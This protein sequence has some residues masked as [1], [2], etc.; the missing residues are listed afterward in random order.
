LRNIA[1]GRVFG[2]GALDDRLEVLVE[3]VLNI[4]VD[5]R[6]HLVWRDLRVLGPRADD[7]VEEV[8]A[9]PDRPVHVGHVDAPGT[10][11]RLGRLFSRVVTPGEHQAGGKRRCH[12]SNEDAHRKPPVDRPKGSLAVV[13]SIASAEASPPSNR[14]FDVAF[15]SPGPPE[16]SDSLLVA[17]NGRDIVLLHGLTA[18]AAAWQD[19]IP[20]LSQQ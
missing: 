1:G 13:G 19:V 10:D 20:L 18:S 11:L 5:A 17:V 16:L 3:L 2:G 7:V 15:G 8:V 14:P 6:A 12:R 4:E 9:G